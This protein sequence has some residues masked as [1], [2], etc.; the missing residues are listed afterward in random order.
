MS[1]KRNTALEVVDA[2]QEEG[3]WDATVSIT[4]PRD[5]RGEFCYVETRMYAELS[6]HSMA[7]ILSVAEK[8]GTA[9]RIFVLDGS[10]G[11]AGRLAVQFIGKRA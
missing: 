7:K 5:D 11:P 4:N 3:I 9:Y 2:L 8:T 10:T 1:M 6:R